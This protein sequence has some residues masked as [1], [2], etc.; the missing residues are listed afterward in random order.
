MVWCVLILTVAA[1]SFPSSE[2]LHDRSPSVLREELKEK[3]RR[4]RDDAKDES[5]DDSSNSSTVSTPWLPLTVC[6]VIKILRDFCCGSLE[7]ATAMLLE[8]SFGMGETGVGLLVGVTLLLTVPLKLAFDSVSTSIS[9][10]TQLRT[11]MF[12][13]VVGSIL[14]REDV[15]RFLSPGDARVLVIIVADICLFPA[16]FLTGA[17]VEGIGFRLASPEGTFFSTNNFNVALIMATGIGRS[18]GPPIGRAALEV[19]SG[20]TMYS[21]QQL[22][23][24]IL[25]IVLIEATLV[26]EIKALEDS[27][28][29]LRAAK[30]TPEASSEVDSHATPAAR[31]RYA[32]L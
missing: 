26:R 25:S 27:P 17:V 30:K 14:L 9:K 20:Q 31:Q 22:L 18:L 19:P 2:D 4:E 11:L 21:Y 32:S 29:G 16:L 6:L 3:S 28:R 15:G 1:F 10:T 12:L 7:A 8:E 23:A 5:Q 13:C 24:S